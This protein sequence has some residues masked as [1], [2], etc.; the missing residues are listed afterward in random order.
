MPWSMWQP[1]ENSDPVG[2]ARSGKL[3]QH[4]HESM[5]MA[6]ELAKR[7]IP[8]IISDW[9]PPEW[10]V[11]KDPRNRRG[12]RLNPEKNDKIYKSLA[13]YLFYL[14]Q[15]YGAEPALF[16]FNESDI[17]INVLQT[18]TEHAEFI[19]GFGAYLAS[20]NI[21]TRLLLGDNSDATTFDFILPALNDPETHKYIG[22]VSFHS[23]RGC[24]DATLR[25]W[26]EA[27]KQLN[28]PL[29]VAEG[30][31]DAAAYT[32]PEIFFEQTFALYELN[33]YIRICALCQPLSIL[34]WQL[35]SDYSVMTGSGIYRTRG[36]L[37]PTRRFWN[38][39]QLASTPE[40]AFSL[41]C[42]SGKEEVNCAAFGNIAR[43]EYAVHI[44]NNGAERFADIKGLPGSVNELY[45]YVTD[46][47]RGMVNTGTVTVSD[48]SFHVSLPPAAMITLFSRKQ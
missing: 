25:K 40:E 44:I 36:E 45:V 41:P 28:V 14:K 20:R 11:I 43:G 12:L 10:A 3:N 22:A 8:I 48:G 26:A 39:R 19:K 2:T 29:I 15:N 1:E 9:A 17:G 24:D 27:A 47:S 7:G 5:L 38:L 16:S 13:D 21:S 31:T 6:G 32:Y 37:R 46:N 42:S 23:W 18:A 35:T 4:V 34:Q 33:L 30:S